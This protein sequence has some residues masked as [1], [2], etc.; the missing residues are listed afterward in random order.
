MWAL[1]DAKARFSAVVE[2]ALAGKP[3]RVTR[4]GKPVV[5]V[6]DAAEWDQTMERARAA[7]LRAHLAAL[8][9]GADDDPFPRATALPRDL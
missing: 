4:R 5:V 9:Q 6:V 8:P 7:G 3:Q 2:A 1:Q